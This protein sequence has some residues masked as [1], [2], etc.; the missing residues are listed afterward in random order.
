ML[1]AE[2]AAPASSNAP[3]EQN[4]KVKDRLRSISRACPTTPSRCRHAPRGEKPSFPRTDAPRGA[5][6][7][8]FPF[9]RPPC[10]S[11]SRPNSVFGSPKLA[12]ACAVGADNPLSA[13]GDI[14]GPGDMSAGEFRETVNRLLKCRGA[15]GRKIARRHFRYGSAVPCDVAFTYVEEHCRRPAER[16]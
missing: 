7:E 10:M 1:K 4:G 13:L 2:P 12:E 5:P 3:A 11:R 9:S 6:R 15:A 14:P 8:P 16:G